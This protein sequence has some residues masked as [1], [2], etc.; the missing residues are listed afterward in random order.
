MSERAAQCDWKDHGVTITNYPY[1]RLSI[2]NDL[3]PVLFY[4]NVIPEYES[5]KAGNNKL[6]HSATA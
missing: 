2:S 5:F 6:F 1:V 4:E 3:N